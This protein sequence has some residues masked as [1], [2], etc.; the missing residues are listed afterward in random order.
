MRTEHDGRLLAAAGR[1]AD[2]VPD[3]VVAHI[4]KPE[5]DEFA[6]HPAG[7]IALAAGRSGRTDQ[8]A[9]KLDGRVE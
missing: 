4:V 5:R 8:V 1:D 6:H 2:H 7:D 9:G 3:I